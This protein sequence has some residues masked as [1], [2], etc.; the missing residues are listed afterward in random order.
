MP[1][2]LPTLA[3][4]QFSFYMDEPRRTLEWQVRVKDLRDEPIH[5]IEIYSPKN[6]A[7]PFLKLRDLK[8]G[9]FFYEEFSTGNDTE[10]GIYKNTA[11]VD[12]LVTIGTKN[13]LGYVESYTEVGAVSIKIPFRVARA[14]QILLGGTQMVMTG[15][16]IRTIRRELGAWLTAEWIDARIGPSWGSSEEILEI[17][18]DAISP[19][20]DADEDEAYEA[21]VRSFSQAL[22]EAD[23]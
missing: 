14:V 23:A 1:T 3:T 12:P 15:Q 10:G 20:E 16:K 13:G 5:T 8:T 17:H 19:E 7:T 18:D 11:A 4:T 22:R 6:R 2:I 9:G 21:S